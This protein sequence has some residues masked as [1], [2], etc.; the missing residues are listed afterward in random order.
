[1]TT[2]IYGE[3]IINVNQKG[4][5]NYI[6]NFDYYDEKKEYYKLIYSS[7]NYKEEERLKNEM[8]KQIN[9]EKTILNEKYSFPVV[10][11]AKIGI[12]G[13]PRISFATFYIEISW[14]PNIGKNVYENIYEETTA[15]YDYSVTW[16]LPNCGNFN[17]IDV[18]GEVY[19]ENNYAFIKVKKGTKINGY[20]SILFD[21]PKS[22]F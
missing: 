2:P 7:L 20:E 11:Y 12:R 15:E 22:C 10:K 14:I 1:M 16:I 13:T 5:I 18:S 17:K 3:G 19:Y 8:Q 4:L 21:L 9:S 6:I